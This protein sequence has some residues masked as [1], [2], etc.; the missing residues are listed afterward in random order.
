MELRLDINYN[1]ILRLIRQL[2]KEDIK[3][4][5][6]TLQSEGDIEETDISLDELILNAPT[7]TDSEIEDYSKARIHFNKSRIA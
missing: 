7:W 6:N 4:L 3:K 2:P 1:Q 5:T